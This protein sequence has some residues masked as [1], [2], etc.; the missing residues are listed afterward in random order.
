MI[1][2]DKKARDILSVYGERDGIV[3]AT[4]CLVLSPIGPLRDYWWDVVELIKY[5]GRRYNQIQKSS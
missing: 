1:S 2:A 5:D 4:Q 3:H